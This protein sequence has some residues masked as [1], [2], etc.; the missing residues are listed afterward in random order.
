MPLTR[1][2]RH[3]MG[4][5]AAD[6]TGQKFGKLLVQE[7]TGSNKNRDAMWKCLCDCGKETTVSSRYLR[8]GRIKSCGCLRHKLTPADYTVHGQ[9]FTR[10]Y[11]IWLGM[12]ARCNIPSSTSF[13]YYGARGITVCPEW[14]NSFEVF[15]KWAVANGYQD[16]LSIDRINVDGNYE[17]SNCRWATAKEQRHNR[18]DSK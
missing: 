13:P 16:G 12:K 15:W 6:L 8:S 7:R 1:K 18:R 11:R 10:L 4:K 9:R 3:G 5:P 2:R 14:A 17:P